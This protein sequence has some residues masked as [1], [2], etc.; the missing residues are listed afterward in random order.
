MAEEVNVDNIKRLQEKA[1]LWRMV[2]ID[3]KL[4]NHIWTKCRANR[5]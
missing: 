5:A 2:R 3:T 1:M 4:T